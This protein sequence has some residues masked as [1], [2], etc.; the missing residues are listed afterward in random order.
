LDKPCTTRIDGWYFI[1][2]EIKANV[3]NIGG[4]KYSQFYKQWGTVVRIKDMSEDYPVVISFDNGSVDYYTL[5]GKMF[6]EFD[7]KDLEDA[8]D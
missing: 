1:F 8:D 4:R 5:D 3:M 6:I 2:R 7:V